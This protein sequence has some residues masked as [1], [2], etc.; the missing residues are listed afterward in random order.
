MP[1]QTAIGQTR[2]GCVPQ[3]NKIKEAVEILS[4]LYLAAR[5]PKKAHLPVIQDALIAIEQI[6]SASAMKERLMPETSPVP[7]AW[8]DLKVGETYWGVM[9]GAGLPVCL[10]ITYTA[11]R[12]IEASGTKILNGEFVWDDIQPMIYATCREA[13]EA[14]ILR[15]EKFMAEHGE[16]NG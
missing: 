11:P 14:M 7:M 9:E 6:E 4:N 1:E 15:L 3:M 2:L 16:G 12:S 5:A 10:E 13:C 8:E